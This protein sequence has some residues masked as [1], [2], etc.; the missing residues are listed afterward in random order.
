MVEE[1]GAG[2]HLDEQF[3]FAVDP[4]G[5]LKTESGVDELQK[6]LAFQMAISLGEYVGHPPTGNLEAKIVGRAKRVA[7]A[8]D[9][10]SSVR[11][12]LTEVSF[13]PKRESISLKIDVI[14]EDG[15][16]DLV[17]NI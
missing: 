1:L 10:V 3:D 14:T 13:G 7:E 6:D 15:Q 12:D 2:I 11:D 9:R 16:Q 4:T 8:D 17:F 5:D